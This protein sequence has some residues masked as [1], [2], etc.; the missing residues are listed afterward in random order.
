MQNTNHYN[1]PGMLIAEQTEYWKHEIAY[2]HAGCSFVVFTC[3]CFGALGPYAIRYPSALATLGLR[4]HE[5]IGRVQ[6][7]NLNRWIIVNV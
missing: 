4:Q 7:M 1:N 2:A 3:S 6:G 5:A